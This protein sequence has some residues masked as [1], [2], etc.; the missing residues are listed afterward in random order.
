MTAVEETLTETPAAPSQELTGALADKDVQIAAGHYGQLKH[1]VRS[2]AKNMG[3]K[4][5]ARVMIALADFPFA[6]TYPK[7]RSDAEQ[8]LFTFMLSI[9]QAKAVI[10]KALESEMPAIQNE[11]VENMVTEVQEAQ[12][13]TEGDT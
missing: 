9:G 1:S 12:T 3:G 7:F 13:K 11:A 2:Y 5:L 6:D 4:G 8:K 10:G